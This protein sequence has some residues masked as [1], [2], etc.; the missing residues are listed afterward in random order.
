MNEDKRI[1]GEFYNYL[2]DFAKANG[3]RV[4]EVIKMD[5]LVENLRNLYLS[6]KGKEKDQEKDPE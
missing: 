6:K 3:I 1:E 2:N 5:K 4:T